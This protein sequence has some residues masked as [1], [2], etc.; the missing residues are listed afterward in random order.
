MCAFAWAPA[1]QG[2]SFNFALAWAPALPSAAESLLCKDLHLICALAWAPALQRSS[3]KLYV[4]VLDLEP[5]CLRI[6]FQ[7][8]TRKESSKLR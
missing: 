2:S 3:F 8:E 1:L 6:I 5:K 7:A 4:C